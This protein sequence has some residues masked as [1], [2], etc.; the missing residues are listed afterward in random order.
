MPSTLRPLALALLPVLLLAVLLIGACGGDEGGETATVPGAVPAPLPPGVTAYEIAGTTPLEKVAPDDSEDLHN[1][2]RLSENVV[3]GGEP[4]GEEA[5]KK[6]ADMGVK[7]ILSVDGKT[8]EE[9]TAAKYG[10]RYVHV[11]IHYSGIDVPERLRIAKTFRELEGPFYVHCFHGRH[12]GPAA[13]AIGR[14]VLD[15][16][17]R[18]RAAAEMRQW[19]GTSKKYAGLYE[20]IARAPLP[21]PADTQAY[22]WDFPSA[23]EFE[24]LRHAMIGISRIHDHLQALSRR[25]WAVDPNH[26]DLNA[27]NETDQ[28]VGIFKTAKALSEMQRKPEDFQ[29]WMRESV[30]RSEALL[31]TLREPPTGT[32]EHEVWTQAATEA[33][34]AVSARCTACHEVY[35]NQ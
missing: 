20:T 23:H 30:E 21:T 25:S 7:T 16:V 5:L 28:L 35:R 29:A 31:A 14:I 34:D 6:I 4:H 13:A 22:S 3:S 15:G 11:P 19:C 2:F 9:K 26:P 18:E 24:G 12:R 32:A 10:L 33:C 8:P 17:S 1:V 27:A